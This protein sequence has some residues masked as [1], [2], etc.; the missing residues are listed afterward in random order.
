L[1]YRLSGDYNPIHVGRSDEGMFGSNHNRKTPAE[2][3][4]TEFSW[5]EA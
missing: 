4:L 2:W 5:K 1:L 3:Q